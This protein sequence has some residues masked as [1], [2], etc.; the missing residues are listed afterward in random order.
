[1]IHPFKGITPKLH[2]SVY[3]VQSAEIIGDV[4]IGADSSVWYNAVVRGDVNCIRIGSRT[5]VQDGC[6][7]HVRSQKYPLLI[8]SNVTLGHGVIAHA[9]T[10]EDFCLIGMGAV[11]LDNAT[12]GSRSLVAAGAVVKNN[13]KIPSGVLV[14]GVPAKVVRDLTEDEKKMLEES[15]ENYVQY[16]QMYRQSHV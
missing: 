11:I 9:C 4:E 13:E 8:G 15:A 7:L 2:E 1:M 16:V 14:A 12:I 6:L 3:T 10:I 5:N